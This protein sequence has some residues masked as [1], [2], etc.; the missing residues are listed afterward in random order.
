MTSLITVLVFVTAI[1]TVPLRFH[2]SE[3]IIA[4]IIRSTT[5][6]NCMIP[7]IMNV[8]LWLPLS[9]T[10]HPE[11]PQVQ[12]NPLYHKHTNAL[13]HYGECDYFIYIFINQFIL[14]HFDIC[15]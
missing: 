14:L 10:S 4:I 15:T 5:A 2:L 3:Y 9:S 11:T 8:A 7:I 13:G 6:H 1:F 12:N